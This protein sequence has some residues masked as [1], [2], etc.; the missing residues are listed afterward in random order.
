MAI[1]DL[2]IRSYI[3]DMKFDACIAVSFMTFFFILLFSFFCFFICGCM[4]CMLL[5]KFC[6]LHNFIVMFML[7]CSY[8]YVYVIVFLLLYLCI[9]IVMFMYYFYVYVIVL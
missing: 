3:D 4:F 2:I 7:L 1:L 5:F 6:K 9:L 8:F